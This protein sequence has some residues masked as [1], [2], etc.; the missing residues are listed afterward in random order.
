MTFKEYKKY[1]VLY[2]YFFTKN[3]VSI[4]HSVF[5][6]FSLPRFSAS[7]VCFHG[8]SSPKTTFQ[9]WLGPPAIET[10]PFDPP[11]CSC[12]F[13]FD[14]LLSCVSHT[15]FIKDSVRGRWQWVRCGDINKS[16]PIGSDVTGF[17]TRSI[18]WCLFFLFD[19]KR[20]RNNSLSAFVLRTLWTIVI[21]GILENLPLP[22]V[23]RVTR[24]KPWIIWGVGGLEFICS[25]RGGSSLKGT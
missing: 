11:Y 19:L 10:P 6:I 3:N 15:Y 17:R 13:L 8:G 14:I 24:R 25:T 1:S 21:N 12:S 4:H 7:Q 2:F 23:Q 20:L 16:K 22:R 18:P 9:L 5:S